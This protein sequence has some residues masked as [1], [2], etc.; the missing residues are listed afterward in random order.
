MYILMSLLVTTL[1]VRI[2]DSREML[3]GNEEKFTSLIHLLF[4]GVIVID[5]L[6]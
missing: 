5:K 6:G 4:D 2:S 3:S 1:S